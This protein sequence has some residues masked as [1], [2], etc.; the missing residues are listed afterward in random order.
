[1][2]TV[3]AWGLYR[4][5]ETVG[6]TK[7]LTLDEESYAWVYVGEIGEI[8]VTSHKQHKA[9]CVLSIGN[10]RLYMVEDESNLLDQLNS[11]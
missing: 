9:D 2:I 11:K 4:L 10:Y 8:L 1:M 6:Q 3:I 5:I 7:I